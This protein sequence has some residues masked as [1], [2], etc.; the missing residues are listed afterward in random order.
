MSSLPI[1]MP[2]ASS[3][4]PGCRWLDLA[5]GYSWLGYA[6]VPLGQDKKPSV[7]WAAFHARRPTWGELYG[8]PWADT[9]GLAFVTGAP[10]SLVIVDAD[11]LETWVWLQGRFRVVRGVKTRRGGHAHFR[12]PKHGIVAN[13]SGDRAIVLRGVMKL[14]VKGLGGM[15]TGPYSIH[16][17]GHVYEPIGDWTFPVQQLPLLP[18]EIA[19]AA[20]EL[21]LPRSTPLPLPFPDRPSDPERSLENYLHKAG[22]IPPEGSGSDEA[23][24]RAAAWAKANAPGLAERSFVDAIR[25]EQPK[26]DPRWI[27]AKWKSAKGSG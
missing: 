23:V 10:H 21:P 2:P 16:P 15:A 20:T 26:F 24:F 1:W 9:R 4:H 27:R 12:H 8:F 18:D 22:G 14:D 3:C 7:K 19:D 5:V 13:R 17:S 6:T 11:D 25:R